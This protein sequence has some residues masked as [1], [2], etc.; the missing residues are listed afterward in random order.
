MGNAMSFLFT[1]LTARAAGGEVLLR[2]DDLDGPRVRADFITGI[3]EDLQWLGLDWDATWFQSKRIGVY[4]YWLEKWR[5]SA[6]IYACRCTR[7]QMQAEGAAG[8][9]T[10]DCRNLGLSLDSGNPWRLKL[11]GGDVIVRRR[12]GMA[13]YHVASL[14]DDVDY[15]VDYI[16]RGED[17]KESTAVQLA[18]AH[19]AVAAG[20]PA[21]EKFICAQIVHHPLITALDGSKLSKSR[22][23]SPLRAL[24]AS[25]HKPSSINREFLRWQGRDGSDIETLQQLRERWG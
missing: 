2:F 14:A 17:L 21:A 4:E 25:G 22:D 9:C 8:T 24:R 20:I 10:G 19:S 3:T 23:D 5:K 7:S 13:A 18:M 1:W 11:D 12:E 16:V 15:G 6:Q